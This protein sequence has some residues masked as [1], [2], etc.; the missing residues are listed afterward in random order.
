MGKISRPDIGE[1]CLLYHLGLNKKVHGFY[2]GFTPIKTEWYIKIDFPEGHLFAS[3]E[4]E[5]INFYCTRDNG[6]K[7]VWLSGGEDHPGWPKG[8]PVQNIEVKLN[9]RERDFLKSKLN[10][11]SRKKSA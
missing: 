2:L 8:I 10:D 6:L 1:D 5:R 9:E 7:E 3:Q 4:G 11:W